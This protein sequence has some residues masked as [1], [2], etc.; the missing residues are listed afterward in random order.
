MSKTK[1]KETLI[2]E[3]ETQEVLEEIVEEA[4]EGQEAHQHDCECG[5]CKDEGNTLADEY[6]QLAQRIKADFENYK[7]RTATVRVDSMLEAKCNTVESFLPVLDNLERAIA[8]MPEGASD[9]IRQGVEMVLKQFEGV[10]ESLGVT[11]IDSCRV[12]FDPSTHHAV[13]QLDAGMEAGQV[14]QIMQKGYAIGDRIVR[15]AMVT[16]QPE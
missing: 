2:E 7:K 14:T 4:D 5:D 3:Q 11:A 9:G 13:A 15:Y 12:A 8:T 16:V 6:L 10:L 1:N